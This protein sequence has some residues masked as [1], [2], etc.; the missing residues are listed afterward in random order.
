MNP[1]SVLEAFSLRALRLGGQGQGGGQLAQPW[2]F[3]L[4]VD[5][6]SDVKPGI[7][8]YIY[9]HLHIHIY[10]YMYIY[11]YTYI[12]LYGCVCLCVYIYT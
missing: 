10:I 12:Y 1:A 7:Q 8:Q 11:I 2:P 6:H 9:I 3:A 4:D 5:V